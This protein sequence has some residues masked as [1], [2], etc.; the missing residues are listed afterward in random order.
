MFKGKY[1]TA[2]R[3]RL[4]PLREAVN[5]A[6]QEHAFVD[7]RIMPKIIEHFRHQLGTSNGHWHWVYD[8]YSPH[9]VTEATAPTLAGSHHVLPGPPGCTWTWQPVDV[10]LG[11]ELLRNYEI[12][13]ESEYDAHSAQ[14]A[15][16]EETFCSPARAMERVRAA[17]KVINDQHGGGYLYWVRAGFVPS[18]TGVRHERRGGHNYVGSEYNFGF[19]PDTLK[20]LFPR[21]GPAAWRAGKGAKDVIRK[22]TD[23]PR[24]CLIRDEDTPSLRDEVSPVA[25]LAPPASVDADLLAFARRSLTDPRSVERAVA[26]L[27]RR[28]IFSLHMFKSCV[29]VTE[30]TD[31]NRAVF[32]SGTRVSGEDH[33]NCLVMFRALHNTD[34]AGPRPHEHHR[35]GH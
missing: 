3:T 8:N 15:D 35:R 14:H 5:S 25:N 7:S 20:P 2:T 31:G 27:Q 17:V 18:P 33:T 9:E 29:N 12:A 28:G 11:N 23:T 4:S 32:V 22:N 1:E 24:E 10:G 30:D 19:D 16:W 13:S 21:E 6:V 26:F 34:L